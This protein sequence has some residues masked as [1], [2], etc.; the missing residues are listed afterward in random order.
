MK[1]KYYMVNSNKVSNVTNIL[2]YDHFSL[3][4]HLE[5]RF[6]IFRTIL[7]KSNAIQEQ[8][9]PERVKYVGKTEC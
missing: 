8:S 5:G 4:L 2:Q 1:H 6:F 3:D 9:K 7:R